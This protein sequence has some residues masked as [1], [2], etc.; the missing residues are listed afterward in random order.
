MDDET[1]ASDV[2]DDDLMKELGISEDDVK[3]T[4]APGA[5]RPAVP[6]KT[7]AT[8]PARP[9]AAAPVAVRPGAPAPAAAKPVAPRPAASPPVAAKP[10]APP[11]AKAPAA[12]PEVELG[13]HNARVAADIP[14]QL[15][16]VMAKQALRLKDILQLKIGDVMDFKRAPSEPVDLV[17]NGKLVAK[18]ELVLVDGKVGVRILKLIK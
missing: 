15:A 13:E 14:V 2:L 7:S 8:T 16:V 18:A 10:A 9:T 3:A 5:P 1:D 17:G 11:A 6:P 12:A 4:A